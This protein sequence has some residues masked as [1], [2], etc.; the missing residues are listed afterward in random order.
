M[1]KAKQIFRLHEVITRMQLDIVANI[2]EF[3]D[4]HLFRHL[5]KLLLLITIFCIGWWWYC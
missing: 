3:R 1:R 5:Q 2:I 4:G